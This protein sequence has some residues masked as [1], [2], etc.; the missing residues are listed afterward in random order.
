MLALIL[1]SCS[2]GE[3]K[4]MEEMMNKE[5]NPVVTIIMENDDKLKSNYVQRL[6]RIRF[7]TLYHL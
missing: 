6:P 7:I 5:T 3:Q 2:K 1:A 4:D